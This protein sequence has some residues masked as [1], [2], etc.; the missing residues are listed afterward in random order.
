ME[1]KMAAKGLFGKVRHAYVKMIRKNSLHGK[2]K[3]LII[4]NYKIVKI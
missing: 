3:K 4:M 2:N 1:V